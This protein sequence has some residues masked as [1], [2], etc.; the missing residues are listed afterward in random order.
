MAASTV[1][2]PANTFGPSAGSY[3][4]YDSI[5]ILRQ[6]SRLG[7]I[8]L[9]LGSE[10]GTE[11]ASAVNR[12]ALVAMMAQNIAENNQFPAPSVRKASSQSILPKGPSLQRNPQGTTLGVRLGIEAAIRTR[13]N[14]QSDEL[15]RLAGSRSTEAQFAARSS[16]SRAV[17][18]IVHPRVTQFVTPEYNCIRDD[19]AHPR[20]SILSGNN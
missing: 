5:S 4:M 3:S 11:R 1:Y 19:C 9:S 2:G 6:A 7:S 15:R 20:P 18:S 8:R 13:G 10:N 14:S 16:H 12:P 17:D